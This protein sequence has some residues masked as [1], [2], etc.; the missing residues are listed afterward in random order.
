[1]K[2]ELRYFQS[3]YDALMYGGVPITQNSVFDRPV[4]ASTFA[5]TAFANAF[6]RTKRCFQYD[7]SGCLQPGDTYY[8]V[9]HNGLDAMVRRMLLEMTLLS[10]D[11]DEDVT[12]NSTRYMYMYAVGGKD[13]YDGLQQAAQLF[14][15]YSISRYN[16]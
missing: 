14:A 1:L 16:Q 15:D 8:E 4:P 10:Q 6:F 5:S 7:Q 2:T 11:E 13:L 3:E 12:Y 9:T